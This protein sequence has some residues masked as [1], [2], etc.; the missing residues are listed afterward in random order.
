MQIFT[1]NECE[2]IVKEFDAAPNKLNEN[3][4]HFYYNSHGVGDLPSTL[5]HV[6]R[7]TN[8]IKRKYPDIIF[9]NTYIREYKNKSFLKIH[10]DRKDLDLTLSICLHKKTPVSW[11]LCISNTQYDKDEWDMSLDGEVY[12]KDFKAYDMTEGVGA[13]CEGRKYPHWRD[14]LN[15]EDDERLVY[16][17]YHWKRKAPQVIPYLTPSIK[18]NH[19]K[20]FVYENF[21]SEVE[22]A[23]LIYM[24]QGKLTRSTVVSEKDGSSVVHPNRTSQGTFFQIGE[25]PIIKYIEEK[26]SKV[27]GLPVE[28]GEG[29]QILRYGVGEEYKPH[30]DYFD[31][32][33]DGTQNS[34]ENNR[35]CT[36]LMYLNTPEAGGGTVFPDAG[37]EIGAK[38]GS[39]LMFCYDTPTPDTKTLHGGAPVIKGEK[40][41]ATKWLR[42]N[43]FGG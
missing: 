26:I 19:P 25:N 37:I 12:K 33:H 3:G 10:T 11:P 27:T 4:Q 22:C 23:F 7:I 21:L 16:V 32:S 42:R 9:N 28:N 39:A 5:K 43:K 6:E 20:I 29:L 15:C 17:F 35:I 31:K 34:N 8:L 18:I 30:H 41:A 2:E 36:F 1:S 14:E 40:W 13:I 24:S 38:K